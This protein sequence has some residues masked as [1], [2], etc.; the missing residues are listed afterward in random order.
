MSIVVVRFATKNDLAL[1]AP[2]AVSKHLK[3]APR[4]VA[5]LGLALRSGWSDFDARIPFVD[6]L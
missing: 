1:A 5:G 3:V 2:K 4:M 6:S